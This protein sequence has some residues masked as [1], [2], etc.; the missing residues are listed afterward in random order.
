VLK[1]TLIVLLLAGLAIVFWFAFALWSGIYSVYSYPPSKERPEGA[2]L[3][4]SR[5]EG[6]PMFNSPQYAPPP[7]PPV[8]KQGGITFVPELKRKRPVENRTVLELPYSEWAYKRS[9]SPSTAN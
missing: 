9:L 2:T 8:E 5:D 3:I 6:E 4:I 7:R 1:K